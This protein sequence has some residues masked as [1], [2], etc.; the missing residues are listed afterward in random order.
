MTS[1]QPNP[2]GGITTLFKKRTSTILP[3]GP[4]TNPYHYNPN[5]Y[6]DNRGGEKI[7]VL[8]KISMALPGSQPRRP[9]AISNATPSHRYS[10]VASWAATEI[11][12][13]ASTRENA[14][15]TA[16]SNQLVLDISRANRCI[17]LGAVTPGSSE[18]HRFSDEIIR[19]SMSSAGYGQYSSGRGFTTDNATLISP[20]FPR[21][22]GS[23]ES[24]LPTGPRNGGGRLF[25]THGRSLSDTSIA[26]PQMN[27]HFDTTRFVGR[28]QFPRRPDGRP[29]KRA[30]QPPRKANRK[31]NAPGSV[32]SDD[33]SFTTATTKVNRTPRPNYLAFPDDIMSK[34]SNHTDCQQ[35]ETSQSPSTV[36]IADPFNNLFISAGIS[37]ILLIILAAGKEI[38]YIVALM[39]VIFALIKHIPNMEK[40]VSLTPFLQGNLESLIS[41]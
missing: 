14:R 10:E 37:L 34:I 22:G 4:Q 2:R 28:H 21:R 1:Q 8:K 36:S 15:R 11:S 3:Y 31:S 41:L 19:P 16:M 6:E 23:D 35:S 13:V 27:V 26:P 29:L 39:P 40:V 17:N 7:S 9:R 24:Y 25:V 20:T 38:L 33:R 30:S 32:Y 18:E 12:T 5:H